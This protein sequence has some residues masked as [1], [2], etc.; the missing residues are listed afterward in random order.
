MRS[1]NQPATVAQHTMTGP[2]PPFSIRG[3]RRKAVGGS[4]V[5][6]DPSLSG[7]G[8]RSARE[9]ADAYWNK[10]AIGAPSAMEGKWQS[11]AAWC[12]WG[13][14]TSMSGRLD[15][16]ERRVSPQSE[17]PNAPRAAVADTASL[18]GIAVLTPLMYGGIIPPSE[19]GV[20]RD[21]DLAPAAGI[22]VSVLLSGIFWLILGSIL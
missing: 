1:A 21:H 12:A 6:N 14:K 20:N 17:T 16:R 8:A 4:L 11:C 3:L 7:S 10:V 2:A 15:V 19:P 22:L 18:A 5:W 9:F 13:D